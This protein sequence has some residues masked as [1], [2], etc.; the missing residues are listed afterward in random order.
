MWRSCHEC[1]G[2]EFLW[3]PRLLCSGSRKY[4]TCRGVNMKEVAM[5]SPSTG[6]YR[7]PV[8]P[9]LLVGS[10][11]YHIYYLAQR[12]D[13]VRRPIQSSAGNT[14]MYSCLSNNDQLLTRTRIFK[15]FT[16]VSWIPRQAT[17]I[18]RTFE[19][20]VYLVRAAVL[21]ASLVPKI[22]AAL[23]D[24]ERRWNTKEHHCFTTESRRSIKLTRVLP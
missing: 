5:Y 15:V 12:R 1:H 6:G 24:S 16:Y 8:D 2:I 3:S 21:D 22:S 17:Q 14:G 19:S 18:A 20:W 4:G 13:F 7:G 11:Y 9:V 23:N 10:A